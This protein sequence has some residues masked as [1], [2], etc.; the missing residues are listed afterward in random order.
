MNQ[1]AFLKL[2]QRRTA[3]IAIGPS[4]ARRMGPKGTIK[5]AREYLN[6]IDLASL[7][8]NSESEFAKRLNDLT[9]NFVRKMPAGA[10]F[11]GSCR[12]FLNI[13][14]RDVL[15]NHFLREYFQ[16]GKI[17]RWLELPLD[18][19]VA[20]GLYLESGSEILPKWKTVKNLQQEESEKFQSFASKVALRKGILR[21]H[22]DL[23]YWRGKHIG[24]QT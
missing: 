17:E 22:L 13:F 11:W 10:K 23:E 4:T 7:K 14:L 5:R 2:M 20:E 3:S 16:L 1:S 18:S 24:N 15:Y 8:V 9:K 6:E 21:V 12:K 19:H